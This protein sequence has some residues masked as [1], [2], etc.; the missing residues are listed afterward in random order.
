[1]GNKKSIIIVNDQPKD[2][3]EFAALAELYQ[4]FLIDAGQAARIVKS[5]SETEVAADEIV[6]FITYYSAEAAIAAKQQHPV[7]KTYLLT[8]MRTF[9]GID[10][11]IRTGITL[12]EKR[13][14]GMQDQFIEKV[15]S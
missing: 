12:V 10:E 3:S 1:M 2:H 13:T 6:V 8:S 9:P 11:I 14:D 7:N 15:L 5:L 4:A